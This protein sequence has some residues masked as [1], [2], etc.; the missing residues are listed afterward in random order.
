MR[1]RPSDERGFTLVELLV[2]ILIMGILAAIALPAFLGQRSRAQ[3]G[4]AK[5]AASTAA[6]AMVI[7]NYKAGDFA[8]ATPAELVAAEPSLASARNL[9]VVSTA[10]TF[11][12]SVDSAS[13]QGGLTF[14]VNWLANGTTTHTCAVAGKGGCSA[15]GDW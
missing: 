10:N 4:A 2:V 6:K 11:S 9:T 7:Y 3:D 13:T 14:T 8:G 12:V 1:L 5:A 15:T